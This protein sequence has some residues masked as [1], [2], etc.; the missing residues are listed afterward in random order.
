MLRIDGNHGHG[1][2]SEGEPA[3]DFS[4]GLLHADS[5]GGNLSLFVIHDVASAFIQNDTTVVKC[6]AH[7]D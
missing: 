6:D 1:G 3:V 7:L 5:W 2:G 4:L